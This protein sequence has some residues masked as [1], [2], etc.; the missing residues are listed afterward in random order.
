M[1]G[2]KNS[3]V[4]RWDNTETWTHKCTRSMIGTDERPQTRVRRRSRR[5]VGE[6]WP[7]AACSSSCEF[8]IV[9][10]DSRAA[11]D[12]K[13][14]VSFVLSLLQSSHTSGPPT[15]RKTVLSTER[16]IR[17]RQSSSRVPGFR[18]GGGQGMIGEP[19]FWYGGML[20]QAAAGRFLG[21]GGMR[22]TGV[23]DFTYTF[24]HHARARR[25]LET[26]IA[27]D[28]WGIVLLSSRQKVA[29]HDKRFRMQLPVNLSWVGGPHIKTRHW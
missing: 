15:I 17:I 10:R 26:S 2:G 1:R 21:Y 29:R 11:G 6:R 18:I 25:G 4:A 3:R 19:K 7:D 13:N 14:C 8:A 28:V 23:G 20:Q 16:L 27:I 22:Q 5:E 9:R 12:A 24:T